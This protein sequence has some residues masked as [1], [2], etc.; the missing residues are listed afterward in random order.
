[1]MQPRCIRT[2]LTDKKAAPRIKEGTELTAI[3]P[4]HEARI[5]PN[6]LKSLDGDIER[7]L[8]DRLGGLQIKLLCGTK[9]I[10]KGEVIGAST[11][12]KKIMLNYQ[13]TEVYRK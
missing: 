1:M 10:G 7:L 2:Y 11:D 13:I 6:T 4:L 5:S 8:M 9:T 12:G 3:L